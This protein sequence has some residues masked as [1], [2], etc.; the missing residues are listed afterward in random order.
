MKLAPP[1][2]SGQAPSASAAVHLG[3]AASAAASNPGQDVLIEIGMRSA[4]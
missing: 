3:I 1:A 4:G 2:L